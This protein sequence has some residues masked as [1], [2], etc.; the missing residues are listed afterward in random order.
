MKPSFGSLVQLF[1]PPLSLTNV[2]REESP[3]NCCCY[4]TVVNPTK[5]LT[6]PQPQNSLIAV[7][8]LHIIHRPAGPKAAKLKYSVV[9]LPDRLFRG[10]HFPMTPR[11]GSRMIILQGC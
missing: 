11:P 2:S 9:G 8:V 3:N 1:F 7:S 5:K 6:I 4:L 10:P